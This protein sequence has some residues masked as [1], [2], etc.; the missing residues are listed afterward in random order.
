MKNVP[1]LNKDRH[2][3]GGSPAAPDVVV[4]QIIVFAARSY[5]YALTAISLKR[6]VRQRG[7]S[8]VQAFGSRQGACRCC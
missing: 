4:S 8:L 7:L 6:V 2:R 1:H 3:I 5:S